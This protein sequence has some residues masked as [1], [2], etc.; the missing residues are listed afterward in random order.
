MLDPID[1][2]DHSIDGSPLPVAMSE[3]FRS[4]EAAHGAALYEAIHQTFE[5]DAK[6]LTDSEK[7][8][9]Q[10]TAYNCNPNRER[11]RIIGYK[12]VGEFRLFRVRPTVEYPWN[13]PCR[14]PTPNTPIDR[15]ARLIVDGEY[16]RRQAEGGRDE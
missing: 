14:T 9:K 6:W 1:P 3:P 15:Q 10:V 5:R 7:W 12:P 13:Q 11:G 4:G 16:R 8:R 2:Q